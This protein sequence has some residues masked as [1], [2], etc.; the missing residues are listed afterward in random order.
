MSKSDNSVL[1]IMIGLARDL[2]WTDD[3]AFRFVL[4]LDADALKVLQSA[5]A[6]AVSERGDAHFV[7]VLREVV[8]QEYAGFGD[9]APTVV[10]FETER[11]DKGYFFQ[12]YATVFF[13]DGS[14]DEGVDFGENLE[15]EIIDIYGRVGPKAQLGVD[16]VTGAV[17]YSDTGRDVCAALGV[18]D[19]ESARESEGPDD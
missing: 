3:A 16:L 13:P 17:Q 10:V 14:H 2:N 12:R 19:L 5:V 18:K 4:S 7:D 15:S 9:N 1:E 6:D 11:S 8:A